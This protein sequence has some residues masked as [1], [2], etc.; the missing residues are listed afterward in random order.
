MSELSDL[1]VHEVS[2]RTLTGVGGMGHVFAAP[3]TLLAY[4]D[5]SR[6]LVRN[7]DAREVVSGSTLYDVDVTRSG[8][9]APGS[10]VQLPSGREATVL[11]VAVRTAGALGL[12]EHIEAALT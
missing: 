3:V 4:V 10:R 6:R 12:P 2:V 9:Y 5:D 7:A 1:M 11:M 8:V